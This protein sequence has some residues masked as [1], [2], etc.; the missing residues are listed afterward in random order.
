MMITDDTVGPHCGGRKDNMTEY[1]DTWKR[2]LEE[3]EGR[4]LAMDEN[5]VYGFRFR[6]E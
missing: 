4:G 2:S 5:S 1:M 3:K 6:T